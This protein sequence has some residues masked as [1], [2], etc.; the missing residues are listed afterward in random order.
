[1]HGSPNAVRARDRKISKSFCPRDIA[2]GGRI[3]A[4]DIASNG[5]A[6]CHSKAVACLIKVYML[7]CLG[8]ML[9]D[10]CQKRSFV[11]PG[12]ETHLQSKRLCLVI[13]VLMLNRLELLQVASERGS[14]PA[15]LKGSVAESAA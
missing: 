6:S 3:H 5:Q 2:C 13:Y 11:C 4:V 9:H 12:S 7:V 15:S 10:R 8:M 1:M 14:C